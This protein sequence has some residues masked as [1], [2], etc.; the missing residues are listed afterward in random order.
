MATIAK[1]I[2]SASTNGRGIKVAATATP[3]TLIHTA[4]T[5]AL[6]EITA[7]VTNTDVADRSVTFEMG[8]T[9]SPNDHLTLIVPAG[10]TSLVIPAL[11]LTGGVALRAYASTA[12][13]LVVFGYVN[14]ITA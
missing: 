9:T 5:T 14:R 6:D 13:V 4:D 12:N 3:G 11:I 2:F 1:H 10:E 7:Y 8:G